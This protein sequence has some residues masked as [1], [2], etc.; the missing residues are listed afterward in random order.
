MMDLTNER[1]DVEW[2]ILNMTKPIFEALGV[3]L[4]SV[5]MPN[6]TPSSEQT[7]RA[8]E[9]AQLSSAQIQVAFNQQKAATINA[10]TARISQQSCMNAGFTTEQACLDFL[11]IQW[12][13]SGQ[14][15]PSNLVLSIGSEIPISYPIPTK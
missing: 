15:V 8:F 3:P 14:N 2:A 11:M 10:E 5:S 12:L 4:I 6:W 7:R 9:D 13:S 1:D